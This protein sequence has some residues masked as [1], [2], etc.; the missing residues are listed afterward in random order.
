MRRT[1]VFA[2]AAL[3]MVVAVPSASASGDWGWPVVG[4]V[5]RGF[6]P[7]SSPYGAGHRGIDIA[8]PFGT[9]VR[10]AAPGTV[11][12]AGKVAGQL[13]VTVNHGGGLASTCSWL[14]SILVRKGAVVVAGD[15]LGLSGSGHPGSLVPHLHFGVK[16]GGVYVDPLQY[17]TSPS[18]VD[19][20]RL[21][22]WEGASP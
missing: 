13:F 21:A 3:C 9:P 6:D 7:P 14:S 20:I 15:V 10:A 22:P 4:P 2:T 16:L 5:I 19:L 11:S 1:L 8:T 12:F 17:L 18:V